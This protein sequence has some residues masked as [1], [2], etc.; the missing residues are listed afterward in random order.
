[1]HAF[2][3]TLDAKEVL[4]LILG[5]SVGAA[6]MTKIAD[7]VSDRLLGK[8]TPEVGIVIDAIYS[9]V[10]DGKLTKEEAKELVKGAIARY[11]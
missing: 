7:F 6:V 8:F 9:R 5:T 1:M 10:S 11:L 2:L 3:S 4:L